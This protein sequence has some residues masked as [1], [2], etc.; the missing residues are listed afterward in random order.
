LRQYDFATVGRHD[1]VE[2]LGVVAGQD[3]EFQGPDERDE[4]AGKTM[5]RIGK[6]ELETAPVAFGWT[7]E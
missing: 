7:V 1:E 6:P 4:F 5:R 3:H 2:A